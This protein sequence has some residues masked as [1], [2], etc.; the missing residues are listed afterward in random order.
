[1]HGNQLKPFLIHH[2][3]LI[4]Y[5]L[6]QYQR[7]IEYQVGEIEIIYYAHGTFSRGK[8]IYSGYF[9]SNSETYSYIQNT[10]TKTKYE[11][12]NHIA[13]LHY[14][15]PTINVVSSIN[16]GIITIKINGH[17]VLTKEMKEAGKININHYKWDDG[18]FT[19]NVTGT[20]NLITN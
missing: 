6:I 17:T 5:R 16:Q 4:Q 20:I 10:W 13:Y 2:Y 3:H 9:P 1:M 18:T 11:Y 15:R 12:S 7:L 8:Y 14:G 19:F